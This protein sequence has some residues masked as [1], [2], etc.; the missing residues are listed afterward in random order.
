MSYFSLGVAR[1]L[2]LRPVPPPLQRK[3]RKIPGRG[4]ETDGI[5][6]PRTHRI[7]RGT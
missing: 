3:S 4:T 7:P 6:I 5:S 1:E 2:Q